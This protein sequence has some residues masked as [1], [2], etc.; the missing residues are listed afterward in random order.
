MADPPC[1]DVRAY[2]SALASA[3]S[4]GAPP[5]G[6]WE[7]LSLHGAVEGSPDRPT[8]TAVGRHV[9]GELEVR[10][11]RTDPLPLST[12]AQMLSRLLVEFDEVAKTAEYFL[13]DLG[14][15]TPPEAVP[16]LRPVALGL[17][18]RRE[19]PEDLAEE[20]RNVWGGVEVMGGGARDRLL[21][22]ELLNASSADMGKVYAPIM[23]TTEKIRAKA[24]PKVSAVTA[25]AILHLTAGMDAAVPLET[26]L[27]LR[28]KS[29]SD[30]AAALLAALATDPGSALHRRDTLLEALGANPG[31][32]DA[33]HAATYLAAIGAEG[34]A[35]T[36]TRALASALAPRLT[37]PLTAASLL[38][39]HGRLSARES[40]DWV[41][42]AT[43]ILS[44]R[45]LAPN[46][47]ELVALAVALVHGLP[48]SEFAAPS[49][50]GNRPAPAPASLPALTAIHAWMYRPLVGVP[51][52]VAPSAAPA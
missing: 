27:E 5:A 17:A 33:R 23:S 30:E 39:G 22:A 12:V 34:E 32:V 11:D 14:P 47:P 31:S 40:L 25:A 45:Q 43:E 15:V 3:A 7:A 38:S 18:N 19:S 50:A 35:V 48:D 8:L 16:L 9:L 20:F 29:G 46:R 4:P 21:A 13:T 37:E 28:P 36:R 6:V 24:G 49:A 41:D 51:G 26:F 2:M 1:R 42:K 10:A 44:G 52:P